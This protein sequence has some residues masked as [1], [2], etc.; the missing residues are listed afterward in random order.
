MLLYRYIIFIEAYNNN[1]EYNLLSFTTFF[2]LTPL[3]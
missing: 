1:I 2:K 3:M